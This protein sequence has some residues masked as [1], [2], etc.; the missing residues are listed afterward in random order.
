MMPSSLNSTSV[1][2][3]NA[4]DSRQRRAVAR[5][6]LALFALSLAAIAGCSPPSTEGKSVSALNELNQGKSSR[7][8]PAHPQPGK[9]GRPVPA[10][11]QPGRQAHLATPALV[12]RQPAPHCEL[13]GLVPDI[14]D[15]DLW[16]RLKLDYEQH[17]YS[18]KRAAMLVRRQLRG[19][20]DAITGGDRMRDK[21][22]GAKAAVPGAVAP[23][24]SGIVVQDSAATPTV[25][26]PTSSKVS[27]S[28]PS[29]GAKFY[30][31]SA[32]AAYRNGDFALALVDFDLAIG[33]DPS[34]ESAYIDRGLIL[35]RF[36][37]L[38]LAFD[39]VT[40]ARRIENSHRILTPPFPK[41]SPLSNRN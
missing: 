29:L 10:H 15:V 32:I 26:G 33:L 22:E 34:F 24:D 27:S 11:P 18:Y 41:S 4:Q 3:T 38:N 7:S 25:V 17:C 40:R 31:E 19:L 9:S 12:V 28:S 20:V 13:P 2:C 16:S 21:I 6:L 35:Y 5:C 37:V 39:D 23:T 30:C 8:L 1:T 14:V 36:G